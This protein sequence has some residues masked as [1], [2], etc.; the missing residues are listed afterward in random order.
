MNRMHEMNSQS[1]I[2]LL[3]TTCERLQDIR[4]QK[5]MDLLDTMAEEL[6][7][8]EEELSEILEAAPAKESLG[9]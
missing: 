4:R 2:S 6:D 8:L 1:F 7:L 9:R 3:D 5:Y